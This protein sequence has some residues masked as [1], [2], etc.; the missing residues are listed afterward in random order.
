[1]QS[2]RHKVGRTKQY[3][4]G[5]TTLVELCAK[6]RRARMESMPSPGAGS[7]GVEKRMRHWAGQMSLGYTITSRSIRRRCKN[8]PLV[9]SVQLMRSGRKARRLGVAHWHM[10]SSISRTDYASCFESIGSAHGFI[11]DNYPVGVD[12]MDSDDALRGWRSGWSHWC[13]K[14]SFVDVFHV[15]GVC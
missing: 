11:C 13:V 4:I 2:H 15:F 5:H 7:G 8:T 1:M 6:Q 14:L 3:R 12:L 9:V 10:R